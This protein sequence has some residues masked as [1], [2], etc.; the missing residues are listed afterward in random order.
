VVDVKF[1]KK[2]NIRILTQELK[3]AGFQIYGVSTYNGVTIIHLKEEETKDPKPIVD[4]HVYVEPPT[5]EEEIAEEERKLQE[6][7]TRFSECQTDSERI[8]LLAKYL[9]LTQGT[10]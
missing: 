8:T 2:C 1:D 3:D 5:I 4:A 6:W 10:T 9:N 7:R